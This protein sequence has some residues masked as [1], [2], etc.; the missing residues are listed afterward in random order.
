MIDYANFPRN[1]FGEYPELE[2]IDKS[3]PCSNPTGQRHAVQD[4]SLGARRQPDFRTCQTTESI[5]VGYARETSWDVSVSSL[6]LGYAQLV[7]AVRLAAR[8]RWLLQR[9]RSQAS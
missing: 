3:Q 6:V 9:S 5:A 8:P 2:K 1:D 4:L 7:S